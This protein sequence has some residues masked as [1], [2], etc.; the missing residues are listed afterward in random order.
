MKKCGLY[1]RVSTNMQAEAKDGSLDTQYSRL[2]GYVSFR[3]SPTEEWIIEEVYREEGRSGKDMQR[4][5][6]QRMLGDIHTNRINVILCTKLDRITRSLLDFHQL[7][8]EFQKKKSKENM[9]I[10]NQ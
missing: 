3:N 10:L 1:L 5:E 2:E 7:N 8:Q 4:P 6:L 9:Q